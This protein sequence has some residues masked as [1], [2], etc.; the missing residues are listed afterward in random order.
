VVSKVGKTKK[1]KGSK[2]MAISDAESLP[3]SILVESAT[4]SEVKL[5]QETLNSV[6]INQ[7]PK[8]LVGD[9]LFDS[10]P[11]DDEL[12]RQGVDLIAPHKANRVKPPTQDKTELKRYKRRWKIERLFAW[13]FNFRR[14]VVRWDVKPENYLT[15]VILGC[16][17]I[18]LRNLVNF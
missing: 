12:K 13:L 8:K 16:L 6:F 1:G 10:D 2:I 9:K 7:K 15:F 14:I 4:P 5:V 17:I 18:L 11:L 3:I